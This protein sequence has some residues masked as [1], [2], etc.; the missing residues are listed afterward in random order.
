M[1][2]HVPKPWQR[3][4]YRSRAWQACRQ[5]VID[6][7][8]GLCADCLKHGDY[9]PIADVHHVVELTEDNVGNPEISLN[10]DNC[11]GLCKECHNARHDRRFGSGGK[12]RVWFDADGVPHAREA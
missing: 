4:F 2:Y 5:A 10:P 6:R 9:T 1:Q 3:Q 11:V 8:H 7:Q 12:G